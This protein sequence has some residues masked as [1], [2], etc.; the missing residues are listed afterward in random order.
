MFQ[1][2]AALS[3]QT[4]WRPWGALERFCADARTLYSKAFQTW[5]SLKIELTF[6]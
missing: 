4:K 5:F 2:R 1:H 6:Q 3:W